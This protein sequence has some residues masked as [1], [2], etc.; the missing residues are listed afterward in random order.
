MGARTQPALLAVTPAQQNYEVPAVIGALICW[1]RRVLDWFPFSHL[2]RCMGSSV[3]YVDYC[4][5]SFSCMSRI[6]NCHNCRYP[7]ISFHRRSPSQTTATQAKRWDF[8]MASLH[9]KKIVIATGVVSQWIVL[10]TLYRPYHNINLFRFV[11]S[12]RKLL[13]RRCSTT[14]TYP[15]VAKVH[16]GCV[17]FCA[18][19][20]IPAYSP[21]VLSLPSFSKRLNF[22]ASDSPQCTSA[23]DADKS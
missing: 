16:R 22:P 4:W 17:L 7:F 15:S 11:V 12:S 13:Y 1:L 20:A 5:G 6:F 2:V 9:R 19:G 23:L 21:P 14:L 3:D 18:S 8:P 10:P